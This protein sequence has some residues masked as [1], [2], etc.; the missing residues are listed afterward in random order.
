MFSGKLAVLYKFISTGV[1]SSKSL[2]I[3]LF[4]DNADE[5]IVIVINNIKQITDILTTVVFILLCNCLKTNMLTSFKY[6][7]FLNC[8]IFNINPETDQKIN[9]VPTIPIN[10]TGNID[11]AVDSSETPP[12]TL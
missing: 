10:I 9:I 6:T 12:V 1:I 2:L 5:S 4:S 7:F 3:V 8:T 11:S